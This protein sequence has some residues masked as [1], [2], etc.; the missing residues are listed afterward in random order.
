MAAN[1]LGSLPV[2][3]PDQLNDNRS[4]MVF[5]CA[6]AFVVIDISFIGMRYFTRHITKTPLGWDDLLVFPT[7]LFS[8]S[9]C[10]MQIGMKNLITAQV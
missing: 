9:V 4:Q 2:L 3:S 6:I 1:L 5:S 10:G 8:V 7:M